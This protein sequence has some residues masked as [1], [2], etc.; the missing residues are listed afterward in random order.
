MSYIVSYGIGSI[1]GLPVVLALLF[2]LIRDMVQKRHSVLR[3]IRLSAGQSTAMK[4]L[5]PY[6]P[7]KA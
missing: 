5:Y 7:I 2:W 4:M 3:I 6:P 1:S